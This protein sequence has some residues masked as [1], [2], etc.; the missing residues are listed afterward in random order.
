[1][2]DITGEDIQENKNSTTS[3]IFQFS[4]NVRQM[5]EVCRM[6]VVSFIS[7]QLFQFRVF[8]TSPDSDNNHMNLFNLVDGDQM[9]FS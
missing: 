8:Y 2:M 1:M 7:S 4:Q 9:D 6:Q 5:V 3:G